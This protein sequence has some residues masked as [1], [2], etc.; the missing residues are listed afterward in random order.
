LSEGVLEGVYGGTFNP[1]H[2]GHLESARELVA[3]LPFR[4]L[5]LVPAAR[6]PHREAPG[7]SAEDRARM[8]DIALDGEDRLCCDRRELQRDGPSYTVE[9]LESLRRELGAA[10][11]IAL[12]LGCDAL[13]GLD[14]WYRWRDLTELAHLVVMARPGW[15]LPD[16]GPVADLLR[17]RAGGVAELVAAPAGAVHCCELT[18]W[19]VTSTQIRAL[20]QSRQDVAALVPPVVLDYIRA[21]GFYAPH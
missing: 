3:R 14:A 21:H 19:P 18:P 2:N 17:E 11:P 12:V 20:L 9:T 10:R 13:L 7:V 4:R 8:V 6:P 1:L 5:R 15:Q 16:A